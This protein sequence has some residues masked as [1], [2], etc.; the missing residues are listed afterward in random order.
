MGK[1]KIY[2]S[3]N[4]TLHETIPLLFWNDN[5]WGPLL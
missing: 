4:E 1:I 3:F 2:T 5:L